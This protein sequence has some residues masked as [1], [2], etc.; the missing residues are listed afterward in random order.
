MKILKNILTIMVLA[1][2]AGCAKSEYARPNHEISYLVGSQLAKTKAGEVS[3]TGE[4]ASGETPSFSSVGFLHGEGV[5]GVQ[6]FY[7]SAPE[8][9]RYNGSDRWAPSSTYYWPKG[10]QSYVNF[11]SWY[12]R[13]GNPD[14][15]TLSETAISWTARTIVA[16]DNILI[17]EE[18]WRQN[19]NASTYH[20]DNAAVTGIPTLF[21]HLLTRVCFVAK[22]AKLSDNGTQWTVTV[23]NFTLKNVKTTGSLS[24]TNADPLTTGIAPWTAADGTSPA[25]TVASET[26]TVQAAGD[27]SLTSLTPAEVLPMRS[28]LPQALGNMAINFDYTIRTSYS[29]D[30][31]LEET[32]SS[33]DIR[34]N[35][36]TSSVTEWG[37]NRKITYTITIDPEARVIEIDPTASDWS[38]QPTQTISIE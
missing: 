5:E 16:D 27:V 31:Y 4:F 2:L 24:M 38:V 11:V 25:W 21:H 33:G 29:A 36:F 37:M 15:A 20:I 14:L 1:G 10:E 32:A 3:F 6:P 13:N 34:L 7:G 19:A 28:F 18:A 23:K 12:D 26:A 30:D 17:A 9:I 8:T 35:S 22:P